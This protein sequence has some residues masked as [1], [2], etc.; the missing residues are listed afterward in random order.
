MAAVEQQWLVAHEQKLIE[1]E[2]GR[3]RDLRHVGGEA[4]DAACNFGDADLHEFSLLVAA[5]GG[6]GIEQ[7]VQERGDVTGSVRRIEPL[8]PQRSIDVDVRE[9]GDE[10]RVRL[11]PGGLRREQA[12]IARFLARE[13]IELWGQVPVAA[14]GL[15]RRNALVVL[16]QR[17]DQARDPLLA[18]ACALEYG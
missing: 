17:P 1:A 5:G 2:P 9:G 13:G 15:E 12:A 10:R 11:R 14:H 6:N 3:R 7:R 16:E 4:V 18:A 8:S